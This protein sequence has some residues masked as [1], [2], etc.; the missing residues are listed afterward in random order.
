MTHLSTI[1]NRIRSRSPNEVIVLRQLVGDSDEG[2]AILNGLSCGP[3]RSEF[4]ED[5]SSGNVEVR[6]KVT[7]KTK[8]R[9]KVLSVFPQLDI[10]FSKEY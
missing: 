8:V 5:P 1:G 3:T 4:G 2:I 7:W 9:E 6:G 10:V